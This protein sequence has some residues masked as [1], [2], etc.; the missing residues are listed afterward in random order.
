MKEF[1]EQQKIQE[2]EQAERERPKSRE[3]MISEIVAVIQ[4]INAELR[5]IQKKVILLDVQG[6][7]TDIDI[8]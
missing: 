7:L 5:E 3:E 1:R 6:E 8:K 4:S 2:L